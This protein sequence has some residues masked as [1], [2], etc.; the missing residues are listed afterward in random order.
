MVLRTS[1]WVLL[2]LLLISGTCMS[3]ESQSPFTVAVTAGYAFF[4]PTDLN[5]LLTSGSFPELKGGLNVSADVGY[6]VVKALSLHLTGGFM[7]AKSNATTPVSIP[8]G[9]Q[10]PGTFDQQVKV[11]AL[12]IGLGAVVHVPLGFFTLGIGGFADWNIGTMEYQLEGNTA[13]GQYSADR[14]ESHLGGHFYLGPEFGLSR[15]LS[16]QVQLGY[17]MVKISGFDWSQGI[18]QQNLT[19]DLSGTYGLVGL[20]Y[21]F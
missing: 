13:S 3:Q 1:A 4:S 11:T 14:K 5:K 12:P 21:R 7:L 18:F 17:Q 2:S 19:M 9:P 16:L 15:G 8:G 20:R 6:Y 10:V